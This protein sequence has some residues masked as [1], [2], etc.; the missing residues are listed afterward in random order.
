MPGS[1]VF[2]QTDTAP[3]PQP[4]PAPAPTAAPLTPPKPKPLER[5]E[6]E[7]ARLME[8][9]QKRQGQLE[10][11]KDKMEGKRDERRERQVKAIERFSN[12]LRKVHDRALDRLEAMAKRIQQHLDRAKSRGRDV[13]AAQAALDRATTLWQEAKA[14]SAE[15]KSKLDAAQAAEDPKA[16]FAEA[17]SLIASYRDK[18]KA[19]H[20]A[21]VDSITALRG[22]GRGQGSGGRAPTPAPTPAPAPTPTPEATAA[23]ATVQ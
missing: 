7:K 17:R 18:L 5:L 16:A 13:A 20:R 15:V 19:V 6:A 9:R 21:L 10:E 8:E 3:M 22:V 14:F 1:V 4:A 12:Q 2:A 23:P 11:R